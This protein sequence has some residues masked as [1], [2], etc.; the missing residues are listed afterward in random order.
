MQCESPV[1]LPWA[2]AAAVSV[3]LLCLQLHPRD[4]SCSCWFRESVWG[5]YRVD[6]WYWGRFLCGSVLLSLSLPPLLVTAGSVNSFPGGTVLG[7]FRIPPAFHISLR[8]W[9]VFPNTRNQKIH[10]ALSLCFRALTPVW[11]CFF[12]ALPSDFRKFC[13]IVYP[14]GVGLSWGCLAW[15]EL[16]D[17]P[18][19]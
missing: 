5:W 11:C 12:S 1:S 8:D 2:A 13:F 16:L 9:L 19:K 3:R 14:E 6:I 17:S 15:E 4:L 7:N 18:G 10:Q